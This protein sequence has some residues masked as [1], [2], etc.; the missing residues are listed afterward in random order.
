[1]NEELNI[2]E[3]LKLINGIDICDFQYFYQLL[4]KRTVILNSDI[5]ESLI[6]CVYLPLK[7]FE[8]DDS[9]EEVTLILNS[10]GG[11]VSDGFFLANYIANYSKPL[12][13]IVA[14]YACSMATI[15]LAAGGKNNN[16]TRVCYPSSYSLIHDG[17]VALSA[18]EAKTAN[19]ILEFN[20][21]IDKNIRQFIIDN[22]NITP[23][24]YDSKT[25]H[26]WFLDSH[27]MLELNLVDKILGE[28]EKND[29]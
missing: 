11:N 27:E 6:E 22:T 17:F 25:R 16:V 20:N 21:K 3:L 15:I 26:Q 8:E 19:D 23:E 9:T 24:L 1:M 2:A 28:S 13:I 14:G 29:V 7:N 12:K 4:K 18:S 10:G 5:D